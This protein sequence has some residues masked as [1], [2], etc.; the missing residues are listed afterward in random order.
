[1]TSPRIVAFFLYDETTG[2]PLTGAVPVFDTYKDDTGTNLTAPAITE[3]GGGAYKFTPVF[4]TNKGIVY[5][6]DGTAGSTP[7]R[8]SAFL[9]P[10]DYNLDVITDLQ[11]EMLGEWKIFTSGP[12]ANR[13]VL[14]RIDGSV[15][16]KFDLQNSAGSATTSNPF[17]RVPV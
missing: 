17:R 4:P 13:M 9:R 16:K 2:T 12:D 11:D 3:I 14:Y 7:R 6:I 10:E 1:M 5:V 8:Q 15:L